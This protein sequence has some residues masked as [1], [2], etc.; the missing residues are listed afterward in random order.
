MAISGTLES[1]S[2]AQRFILFESNI[3][4]NPL[5]VSSRYQKIQSFNVA[6]FSPRYGIITYS[7][8]PVDGD[9]EVSSVSTV[10]RVNFGNAFTLL[11]SY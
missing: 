8:I 6:Y 11:V 4:N 10:I 2:A 3:H 9:L 7:D 1:R 5:I